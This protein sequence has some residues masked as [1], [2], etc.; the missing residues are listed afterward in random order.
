MHSTNNLMSG[1]ETTSKD[2]IEQP[3]QDVQAL[4]NLLLQFFSSTSY[5]NSH[6]VSVK[7]PILAA[8]TSSTASE[9]T[10]GSPIHQP[11]SIAQDAQYKAIDPHVCACWS[12]ETYQMISSLQVRNVPTSF[13]QR[14]LLSSFLLSTAEESISFFYCPTDISSKRNLGYAFLCFSC[15]CAAS[16]FKKSFS[17]TFLLPGSSALTITSATIQG[18]DANLRN[19][20]SNPTVRRIRNPLY[21]PIYRTQA[22]KFVPVSLQALSDY[23]NVLHSVPTV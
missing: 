3:S 19:V 16:S 6:S 5:P 12:D 23:P 17:G 2:T 11:L 8:D 15:P 13:S 1:I 10:S 9:S 20:L 18:L 22:G 21:M 14:Q 4:L 7:T